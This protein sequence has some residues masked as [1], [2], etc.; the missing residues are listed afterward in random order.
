MEKY[1]DHL[2]TLENC[3]KNTWATIGN[4]TNNTWVSFGCHF[5]VIGGHLG[6]FLVTIGGSYLFLVSSI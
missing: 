4:Y 5:A 3:M 1:G 2:G 6:D